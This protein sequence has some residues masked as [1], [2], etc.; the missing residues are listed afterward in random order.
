[1]W[2]TLGFSSI[3]AD[4]GLWLFSANN[5]VNFIEFLPILGPPRDPKGNS[6][7]VELT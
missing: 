3:H 1:M 2:D 4:M 5:L 6:M 7:V